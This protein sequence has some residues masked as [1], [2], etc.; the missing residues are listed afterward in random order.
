VTVVVLET[1]FLSGQILPIRFMYM[2]GIVVLAGFVAVRYRL[3]LV[4]GIAS[5]W[6]NLR[7]SGYGGGERVLVVGAGAGSEFAAWLLRRSDFRGLYSI[8]GIADDAPSKQGMRYDG[9]KVLG[10][11]ADIPQLVRRYDI[12]V[13][14]H[15]ISNISETDNQRI[16]DTCRR[17][18]CHIVLLPDVLRTLHIFLTKDRPHCDQPCP[19]LVGVDSFVSAAPRG[20]G[21]KDVDA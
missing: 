7:R 10:T 18:G 16:L 12:G 9:V 20:F 4:T 8:I 6:I 17:T 21:M 3:R 5:R 2:A 19:Y 15:A 1:V 14:F 11:T 13:I